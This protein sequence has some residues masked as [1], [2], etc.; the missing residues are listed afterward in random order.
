MQS[1]ISLQIFS[2][3]YCGKLFNNLS[4]ALQIFS[5][6]KDE[7]KTTEFHFFVKLFAEVVQSIRMNDEQFT[8]T[9]IPPITCV[10]NS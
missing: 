7:L 10:L 8:L 4:S 3:I 9:K 2:N 1:P 6:S 5:Q